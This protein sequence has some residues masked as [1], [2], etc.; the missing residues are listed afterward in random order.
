MKS[1]RSWRLLWLG[2]LLAAI[3]VV[4]WLAPVRSWLE[5]L[6]NWLGDLGPWGPVLLGLLF[7][8]A[9]VLGLPGS[10][11]T[12]VGGYLFGVFWTVTAVSI[13]S[14][15][16]ATATFLIGRTLARSWLE[17][18]MAAHRRFQAL[19]RAVGTQGFKIVLLTRLSPIFP[20]NV[21]NY[22][23]GLTQV[24]LGDYVLA[25][26]IGMLPATVMYAY[27]G[28]L[29]RSLTDLASGQ[30]ET[31]PEQQILFYLG[32]AATVIVT[33]LV[34]HLARQALREA[35]PEPR[36]NTRVSDQS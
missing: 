5:P 30:I 2:V 25:S 35:T 3:L 13:G 23:F 7:I 29:A 24:R 19:D 20:F 11:I 10:P 9:C 12:L 6:L 1:A 33:L 34:G 36:E 17:Q 8:P 16:G 22:V 26:W 15:L 4:F 28:N 32:L 14:T 18:C 21:L 27:L 31:T